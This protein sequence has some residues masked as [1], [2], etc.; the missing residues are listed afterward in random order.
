MEKATEEDSLQPPRDRP[1][2]CLQTAAVA[3]TAAV[4]LTAAVAPTAAVTTPAAADDVGEQPL[5]RRLRL[6]KASAPQGSGLAGAVGGRGET[7]PAT[8][9]PHD[10][11]LSR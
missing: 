11:Q 2:V 10:R 1:T 7:P 9:A 6:R 5:V 8:R 4:A 3:A